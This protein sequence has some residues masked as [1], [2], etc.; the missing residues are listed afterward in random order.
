M[1][2]LKDFFEDNGERIYLIRYTLHNEEGNEE[3]YAEIIDHIRQTYPCSWHC[4][5][6]TWI[7]KTSESVQQI[8]DN[9]SEFL[10]SDDA[11]IIMELHENRFSAG[12][13]DEALPVCLQ[14]EILIVDL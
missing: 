13:F 5:Y 2:S 8:F 11:L 14:D 1:I 9:I 10:D 12:R 7:I 3:E 4:L 6:S